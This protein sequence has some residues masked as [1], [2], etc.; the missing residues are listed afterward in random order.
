MPVFLLL[1]VLISLL[2]FLYRFFIDWFMAPFL[3]FPPYSYR[4]LSP[5]L[6]LKVIAKS[7]RRK[8]RFCEKEQHYRYHNSWKSDNFKESN[9]KTIKELI[10][11][12]KQ[13]KIMSDNFTRSNRENTQLFFA[14]W[15]YH[16]YF[17]RL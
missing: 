10:P 17:R 15:G 9:K 13:K 7:N 1:L 6:L 4:N 5:L 3:Y 8:F 11:K 12:M 2:N 16:Y 14:I